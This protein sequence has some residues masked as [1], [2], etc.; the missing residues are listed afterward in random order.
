M[1]NSINDLKTIIFASIFFKSVI[2]HISQSFII[3]R[4]GLNRSR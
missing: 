3:R 4:I 2:Q 1:K